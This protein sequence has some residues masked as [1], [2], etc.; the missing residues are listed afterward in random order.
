MTRSP[1]A[2]STPSLKR[3]APSLPLDSS[4]PLNALPPETI[5]RGT[6]DT[7]ESPLRSLA[8]TLEG[9]YKLLWSKVVALPNPPRTLED[10]RKLISAP[11]AGP[12]GPPEK[13]S[14]EAKEMGSAAAGLGRLIVGSGGRQPEM[15]V[16]MMDDSGKGNLM[17]PPSS[18]LILIT[19]FLLS[20]P[21]LSVIPLIL[22]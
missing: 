4:D 8:D 3:R 12:E 6:A 22:P 1:S 18:P 5:A 15:S 10:V 2:T 11:F 17:Y 21:N 16:T 7:T 20:R 14:R 13:E 9:S 19:I